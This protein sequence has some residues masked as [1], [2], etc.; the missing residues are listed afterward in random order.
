VL[1]Q[2]LPRR[3]AM[4]VAGAAILTYL[5]YPLTVL[6]TGDGGAFATAKLSGLFRLI[7]LV[8]ITGFR[9]AGPSFIQAVVANLDEFATTYALIG[10]GVIAVLVLSRS[11]RPDHRLIGIWTV[12]SY[13]LVAYST[14]FGTLEEQFFYFLVVPVILAIASAAALSWSTGRAR[15]AIRVPEIVLAVLFVAWSSVVWGRF[16]FTPD[17]G[18]EHVRAYLL[19]NVVPGAA[20]GST[21]ETSEFV[22][23]EYATGLWSS[24]DA[25]RAH[26]AQYVLLST[27]QIATGYAI[28]TP[29]MLAWVQAHGHV[30]YAFQ[31]P[32]NGDLEIVEL[33][34]R[35]WADPST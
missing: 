21:T 5:P 14:L 29:D 24:M 26:R 34:D 22:L 30:V 15:F 9:A 35:W 1:D 33:P 6:L 19:A 18:Y 23:D 2:C 7:G 32:T 11:P 8:K 10:L 27:K 25:L 13:I 16:H 20:I 4:L 12:C 3:S 31:G 17:N 28:G